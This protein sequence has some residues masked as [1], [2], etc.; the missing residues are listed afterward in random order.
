LKDL[1]FLRRMLSMC[2]IEQ[3]SDY[4]LL[5]RVWLLNLTNYLAFNRLIAV[6]GKFLG[7]HHRDLVLC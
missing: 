6:F 4:S 2:I 1:K 7:V 3:F 5:G